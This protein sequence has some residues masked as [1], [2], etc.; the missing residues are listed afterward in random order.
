M[1]NNEDTEVV[2]EIETRSLFMF[3]IDGELFAV[4]VEKV[5]RVLKI[6]PITPVPNAPRAVLG[7][8]H[9]RGKVILV[10]DIE[11]RMDIPKVKPLGAKYLFVTKQGEIRYGILVDK[12][13]IIIHVPSK[14]IHE[15]DPIVAAHVPPQYIEGA[16]SYKE[17]PVKTPKERSVIIQPKADKKD[18]IK[19]APII[20]RPVLLLNLDALL[21]QEDLQKALASQE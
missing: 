21:N 3:E 6:P 17:M 4:P 2:E 20:E 15:P 19:D 16:F 7:V 18:E 5:E 1:D 14:E 8:F 10:L 13:R 9:M 12:L 11:T